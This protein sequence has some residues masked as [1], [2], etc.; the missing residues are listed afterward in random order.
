MDNIFESIAAATKPEPAM[1]TFEYGVMSSSFQIKAENKLTA[2]A[3]MAA[4]Y[5]QTPNLVVI[6]APEFAK[7]DSWTSFDGKCADRLDEIFGGDGSFDKYF[8]DHI[9]EIRECY[10]GIVRLV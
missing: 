2:Y 5:H 4:H 7:K 9:K 1:T 3:V 10:D 6:Y 8:E